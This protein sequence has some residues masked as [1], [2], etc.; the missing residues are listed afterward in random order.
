MKVGLA[1]GVLGEPLG[2]GTGEEGCSGVEG[3]EE[4]GVVMVLESVGDFGG[5]L[6]LGTV[7][8]LGGR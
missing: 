3:R 7:E 8:G 4:M 1:K 6:L 5:V 2:L